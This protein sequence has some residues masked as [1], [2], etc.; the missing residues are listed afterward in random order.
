MAVHAA[1]DQF[2]LA[3]TQRVLQQRHGAQELLP[4]CVLGQDTGQHKLRGC[5]CRTI[6]EEEAGITKLHRAG[7]APMLAPSSSDMLVCL[8]VA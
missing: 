5:T 2:H 1:E 7:V 3:V 4:V 8:G 6:P